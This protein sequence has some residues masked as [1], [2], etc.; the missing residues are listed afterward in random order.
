MSVPPSQDTDHEAL[1]RRVAELERTIQEYRDQESQRK[2]L[3]HKIRS[4]LTVIIGFAE[5]LAGRARSGAITQERL[6]DRLQRISEAARRV[7][8]MLDELASVPGPTAESGQSEA[9]ST[10]WRP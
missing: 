1:A 2:V 8:S 4:P 7:D 3:L 6:G 5:T 10:P 9:T